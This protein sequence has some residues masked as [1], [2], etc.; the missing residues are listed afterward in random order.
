MTSKYV[1]IGDAKGAHFEPLK[2]VADKIKCPRAAGD[3]EATPSSAEGSG[4]W[5]EDKRL[6]RSMG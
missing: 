1:S 6:K 4:S 5:S 2:G 3:G